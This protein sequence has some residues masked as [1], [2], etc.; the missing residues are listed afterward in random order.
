MIRT[1][2]ERDLE[3]LS[4]TDED[5]AQE[6]F[7]S[8]WEGVRT[9]LRRVLRS[10]GLSADG[11]DDAMQAVAMKTWSA[12]SGLQFSSLGAW[13]SFVSRVAVNVAIDR[14]R[15]LKPTD[16]IEDENEIPAADIP[17]FDALFALASDREKVFQLADRVWLGNLEPSECGES[18]D[19]RILAVQLV[20]LHRQSPEDVA[21]TLGLPSAEVVA[22][23]IDDRAVAS[24][25]SFR[26]LYHG[27]D[28]LAGHVLRPE[29]PYRPRDLDELTRAAYTGSG[30]APPGW[31]WPDLLVAMW[32]IRNGLLTEQIQRLDRRNPS[33]SELEAKFEKWRASYPFRGI[34]T[35]LLSSI[36][37]TSSEDLASSPELWRRL[38]FQ[39]HIV[40]ELAYRQIIERTEPAA[41]QAGFR[42]TEARL[43]GWIGM[44]RL[45]AQIAAAAESEG[46]H[47]S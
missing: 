35:V 6:A 37:R 13:W 31:N 5:K 28:A 41:E 17:Y 32:R 19:V 23:W 30:D 36:Q 14:S 7:S 15:A 12:R 34:A 39:Y 45:W 9:P 40:D 47:A 4:S 16:S 21:R 27:N 22:E 8:L 33:K 44:G 38:V 29:D 43:T 3:N 18:D 1:S 46:L 24:R 26:S 2:Y 20:L 42:I 25:A 11:C 10:R